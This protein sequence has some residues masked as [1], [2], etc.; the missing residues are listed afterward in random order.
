MFILGRHALTLLREHKWIIKKSALWF[1]AFL[2]LGL[3]L[4]TLAYAIPNDLIAPN[5]NQSIEMIVSE[6]DDEWYSLF[7]NDANMINFG[8]DRKWM[9]RAIV[10]DPSLNALEA[11]MSVN[12][13]TRYWH[14]YQVFVRPMLAIGTY[15]NMVYCSVFSFLLLLMLCFGALRKRFGFLTAFAFFCSLS[16]VRIF[17]TSICLNNSGCFLVAMGMILLVLKLT[18]TPRERFLYPLFLLNGMLVNYIDVLTAPLVALGLPLAVYLMCKLNGEAAPNLKSNLIDTVALPV[19]WGIGY[20]LFW[21][22]KWVIGSAILGRNIITDAVEQAEI[23]IAGDA[24]HATNPKDA[25]LVNFAVLSP[26][27]TFSKIMVLVIVA[28]LA[29]L[30]FL[31]HRRWSEVREGLPLLI[32][33]VSPLLWI[34]VLSNHSEIHAPFVFRILSVLLF[35]LLCFVIYAV[36]WHKLSAPFR[37]KRGK[38]AC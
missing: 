20:G 17:A 4:L 3:L 5:A 36:D 28:A 25:L 12:T 29:L 26:D 9:R 38:T 21:A 24:L 35:A 13:Y 18:D 1:C 6:F 14:G 32:V 15:E 34:V 30:F 8:C 33:A 7:G 16:A 37:A 31:F 10:D 2:A 11:A 27:D 23:R 19:F 22:L